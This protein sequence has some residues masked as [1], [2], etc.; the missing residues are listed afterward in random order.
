MDVQQQV[1][2]YLKIIDN[3]S[4]PLRKIAGEAGKTHDALKHAEHAGHGFA[5]QLFHGLKEVAGIAGVVGGALAFKSAWESSEKYLKNIKEVHE[6]TGATASET[7]FLFSNARKAGVEYDQMSSVMFQLS[8]RG[9]M[10]EQTLL[11]AGTKVPGV[12]AKF[13]RLG[14]DVTK[15]PVTAIEQ[16]SDQVK[17]GKLDAAD[18][19]AQFRVPKGSAN[20]FK[21]FLEKL[22]K[23]KLKTAKKGGAGLL[24]ADDLESFV[25]LEKAQHRIADAWNRIKVTVVSKL[26]PVVADMAERFADRLEGVLPKVESFM[27]AFAG[28]MDRIVLAAK[29]FVAYMTA[30]QLLATLTSLTSA[31]GFIGKLAK[32]GFT[33]AMGGAGGGLTALFT[34]I[35]SIGKVLWAAAGPLLIIAAV[36]A[37]I[38][39]AW[40]AISKNVEGVGDAFH[41]VIDEIEAR[42]EVFGDMFM[43]L[44]GGSGTFS[45]FLSDLVDWAGMLVAT[46]I[47]DTLKLVSGSL[48]VIQA[49]LATL[50]EIGDPFQLLAKYLVIF[51]GKWVS[52]VFDPLIGMVKALGRIV[53]AAVSGSAAG[54]VSGM[55]DFAAQGRRADEAGTIGGAVVDAVGGAVKD[56]GSRFMENMDR[57]EQQAQRHLVENRLAKREPPDKKPPPTNYD[58]RGSRFDI[59]QQFAEGFDPDRIAVSF[60]EDLRA[61]GEHKVQ[62]SYSPV[63]AAGG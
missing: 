38:A 24:S 55:A 57:L 34:Q 20:D 39:L 41:D 6:L 31:S 23:S 3:A 37:A 29:V 52:Q 58:F 62:S 9:S 5:D 21:E 50:S 2:T 18:L 33:K 63:F 46:G 8:K 40:S 36:I 30:K 25:T 53:A 56:W 12:A 17:K 13:K 26:M 61:L 10:M 4:A 49:T 16:M 48:L 11:A 45:E 59:T 51:I 22:D 15:G 43:S 19:M 60:A 1:E 54:V 32:G 47:I 7:D 28:Q 14:V 27:S 44:F 42:F 35:G